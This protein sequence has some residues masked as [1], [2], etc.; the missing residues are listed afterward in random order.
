MYKIFFERIHSI[1]NIDMIV[2]IVSKEMRKFKI[3]ICKKIM[4]LTENYNLSSL[5]DTI[6][7]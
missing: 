5:S 2:E 7:H 4:E 1:R 3:R 6:Q